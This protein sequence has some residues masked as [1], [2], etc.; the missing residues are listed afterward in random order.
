MKK[1]W[2]MALAVMV[3]SLSG[4]VSTGGADYSSLANEHDF[5]YFFP[6]YSF[7][8]TFAAT[9]DAYDYVKTA[10]T[11]FSASSGKAK[12]KGLVAKLSGPPVSGEQP[13]TVFCSMYLGGKDGAIDLEENEKPLAN[14]V[15]SAVSSIVVFLIFHD[16]RAIAIPSYYLQSGYRYTSGNKNVES[17]VYDKNTYSTEYPVGWSVEKAFSYLRKEI[18]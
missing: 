15:R 12:A 10:Q 9:E 14:V 3:V 8:K 16:G 2:G 13:V 7:I 11:K 1:I 17:Y 18:N 5:D 6:S 4:C